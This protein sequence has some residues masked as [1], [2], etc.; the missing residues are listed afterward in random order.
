M[1]II[2]DYKQLQMIDAIRNITVTELGK[3]SKRLKAKL[4]KIKE[5]C[6]TYDQNG[7]YYNL[8]EDIMKVIEGE[9]EE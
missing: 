3:E 2:E 4:K 8:T 7:V 6:Q 1:S 5:I 9:G